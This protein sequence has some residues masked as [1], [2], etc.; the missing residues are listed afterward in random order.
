MTLLRKLE[1]TLR[2]LWRAEQGRLLAF[3]VAVRP[4]IILPA[5]LLS[6]VPITVLLSPITATVAVTILLAAFML[7]TVRLMRRLRMG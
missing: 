7:S 5:I 6:T 4:A 1:Q 3:I 2:G